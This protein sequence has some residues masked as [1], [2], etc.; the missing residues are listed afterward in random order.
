MNVLFVYY[1][2]MFLFVAKCDKPE[3]YKFSLFLESLLKMVESNS[4]Y[5]SRML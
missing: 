4:P 2:A 5:V 1:V 3:M